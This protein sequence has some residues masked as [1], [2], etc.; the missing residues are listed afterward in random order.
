MKSNLLFVLFLTFISCKKSKEEQNKELIEY[1]SQKNGW[2]AAMSRPINHPIESPM[3]KYFY[4]G[5]AI[6]STS[7]KTDIGNS[8]WVT[9]SQGR[10]SGYGTAYPDSV[11]VSYGGLN[12]KME[13]CTYEGGAKLPVKTIEKLFK[14]GYIDNNKKK[15]YSDIITGMAPGGRICVWV[16]HIEV[17]RFILKKKD[18]YNNTPFI[19]F[20]DENEI[21]RYLKNHPIDYSTWEKPDLKYELDYGFCSEDERNTFFVLW[22]STKEGMNE[23]ITENDIDINIWNTPFGEKSN[24]NIYSGYQQINSTKKEYKINLPVDIKLCWKNKNSVLYSTNIIMPKDLPQRFTK[25]YI[26]LISGKKSN[27]NRIVF[28][29]E[30]DGEHCIVWLDGPNKQEKI[31]RFKG[32]I[33]KTNKNKEI[34]SGGYATEVTY[35]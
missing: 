15:K 31:I 32:Q 5:K 33:S 25:S 18:K 6:N 8:G 22:F 11:Y 26:N 27:Y 12:D 14:N 19:I 20:G 23:M 3:V 10:N 29:V 7:T 30:K 34:I 9:S 35:Y 21:V 17:A 28:G 24:L 2:S 1:F 13:M 4:K 16:D